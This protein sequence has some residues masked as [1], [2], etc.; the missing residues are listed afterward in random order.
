MNPGSTAQNQPG[1][2]TVPECSVGITGQAMDSS[3]QQARMEG[4]RDSFF[5]TR[6]VL[7]TELILKDRRQTRTLSAKCWA[8]KPRV[9]TV[10]YTHLTAADEEDSVDLGG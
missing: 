8:A 2:D 3:W 5:P 9:T 6:Y 10:S 1:A 7:P 4:Q